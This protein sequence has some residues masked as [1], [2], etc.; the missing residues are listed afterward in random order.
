MKKAEIY[1]TINTERAA[2]HVAYM[3]QRK[4]R[5]AAEEQNGYIVDLKIR[6][7]REREARYR[8]IWMST[9]ALLIRVGGEIMTTTKEAE[10]YNVYA[11]KCL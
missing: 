1:T 3:T 5:Q 6:D 9:E 11:S 8:G 7:M 10:T 2:A 4:E